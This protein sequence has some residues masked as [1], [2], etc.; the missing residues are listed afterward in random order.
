MEVWFITR[1]VMYEMYDHEQDFLPQLEKNFSNL[2]TLLLDI[3]K[4]KELLSHGGRS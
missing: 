4:L 3:P 2:K 1:V